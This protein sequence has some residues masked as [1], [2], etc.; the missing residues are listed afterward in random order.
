MSQR[1]RLS[2]LVLCI[3]PA[4]AAAEEH[5]YL[6]VAAPGIRNLL[7]FGGA[8]ILVF[9]MDKDHAFV[10]RIET[11]E[12]SAKS[13]D[14]MKGICACA[15]TKRLYFTTPKKLYC[16]DLITEKTLCEKAL[17]QGCDRMSITP[18]GKVLYVPSFE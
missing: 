16:L 12:S 6:Y 8:G 7:E 1:I 18:D 11:P 15:A 17:P 13:P 5:R 10:K 3:L 4:S 2:L 9:D 14:N